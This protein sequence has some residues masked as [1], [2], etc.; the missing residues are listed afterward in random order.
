L[1]FAFIEINDGSIIIILLEIL[2]SLN[3]I[4]LASRKSFICRTW[5][6]QCREGT[7]NTESSTKKLKRSRKFQLTVNSGNIKGV[8]FIKR[9]NC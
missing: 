7:L 5:T 1:Y 8:L 3:H 2:A 6:D 4:F 9:S